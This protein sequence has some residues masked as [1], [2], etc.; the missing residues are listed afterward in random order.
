MKIAVLFSLIFAGVGIASAALPPQYQNMKDLD[1]IV[2]YIREHPEVAAGLRSIDLGA[3]TVYYSHNC[4]AVFGR[5]AIAKPPAWVGPADPLELKS[6]RC[7]D[8]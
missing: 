2:D 7:S 3:L 1:V 5:K 6:S 8:D 4:Q